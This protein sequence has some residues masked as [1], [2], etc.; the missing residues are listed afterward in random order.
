MLVRGSLH[1]ATYK[2]HS[3]N[4]LTYSRGAERVTIVGSTRFGLYLSPSDH[5]LIETD[6]SMMEEEIENWFMDVEGCSDD[7]LGLA[8][9]L[10]ETCSNLLRQLIRGPAKNRLDAKVYRFLR[11]E[12][13]RFSLWGDGFDAKSGVLDKI[14]AESNNLR[15][16]VIYFLHACG[17]CL[18][19][20]A[21]SR[22]HTS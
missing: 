8:G 12:A 2:L 14:L 19:S 15:R 10:F 16:T 17:T 11:T 20:L 9:R 6:Q 18:I 21:S 7:R 1:D 13:H 5:Q 4:R 3:L 22:L